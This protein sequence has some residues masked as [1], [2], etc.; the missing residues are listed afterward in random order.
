MSREA[1]PALCATAATPPCA[2]GAA[3][4]ASSSMPADT[5][6]AASSTTSCSSCSTST[7]SSSSSS[8]DAV[9]RPTPAPTPCAT[10]ASAVSPTTP[11]IVVTSALSTTA[12]TAAAAPSPPTFSFSSHENNNKQQQQQP[13]ASA[14]ASSA[15]VPANPGVCVG[16]SYT[17]NTV[18]TNPERHQRHSSTPTPG[19]S[20]SFSLASAM[21]ALRRSLAP[22]TVVTPASSQTVLPTPSTLSKPGGLPTETLNSAVS[23]TGSHSVQAHGGGGGGSLN[24]QASQNSTV[25]IGSISGSASGSGG[26]GDGSSCSCNSNG[27]KRLHSGSPM[28]LHATSPPIGSAGGSSYTGG[29]RSSTSD[30]EDRESIPR[31]HVVASPSPTLST[32]S[33]SSSFEIWRKPRPQASKSVPIRKEDTTPF[34]LSSAHL[35]TLRP[36][37]SPDIIAKKRNKFEALLAE[38]VVNMVALRKL[39][40]SGIFPELRPVV[41]KLLLGYLPANKEWR[42]EKLRNKRLEYHDAVRANYYQTDRSNAEE[43]I[44]HQIRM[45]LP[46]TCPGTAIFRDPTVEHTLERILYIWALRHSASGYVQGHNDLVIAIFLVILSEYTKILDFNHLENIEISHLT[47]DNWSDVEADCYWCFSKLL[48]GI[49]ANYIFAQPGIQKAVQEMEELTTKLDG[50][51]A[52]HFEE[53]KMMYIQFSFRWFNCLLLREFPLALVLRMWDSY[54]SEENCQGFAVLHTYMCTALL[55]CWSDQLMVKDF[56]DAMTFL[57]HLPTE[58]WADTAIEELLSAAYTIQVMYHDAPSHLH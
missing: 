18:C 19:P 28:L 30:R 5:S 57:Q 52:K 21:T 42:E 3:A 14:S 49:Q 38:P 6:P 20:G 15:Y 8:A 9:V 1:A 2:L 23:A 44:L 46:R 12:A 35:A 31:S 39:S 10:A 16:G 7:S 55:L 47:E 22:V 45:D 50:A 34:H 4:A 54:M 58:N 36:V 11:I 40:W 37:S 43:S 41:W 25:G 56:H 13:S 26:S 53:E 29:N 17:A 27:V 51:L 33:S 24:L 48:D 32:A